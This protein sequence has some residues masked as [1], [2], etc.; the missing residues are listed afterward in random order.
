M[1]CC[2]NRSK[3][4]IFSFHLIPF[5]DEKS[6][7][8]YFTG[9]T[10]SEVDFFVWNCGRIFLLF[11]CSALAFKN[12]NKKCFKK[13]KKKRKKKK[14]AEEFF[15]I[16]AFCVRRGKQNIESS[17]SKFEASQLKEGKRRKEKKKRKLLSITRKM[18]FY[19]FIFFFVLEKNR[20]DSIGA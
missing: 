12:K 20:A 8:N 7:E 6:I 3:F 11:V 10:M 1:K 2:W 16:I 19:L 13:K 5:Q 14:I 15:R 4:S 18:K 17:L 9:E